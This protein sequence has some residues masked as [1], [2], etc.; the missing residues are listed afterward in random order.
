[1]RRLR[2]GLWA[3]LAACGEETAGAGP[4]IIAAVA[5]DAGS[6]DTASTP[7]PGVEQDV[8]AEEPDSAGTPDVTPVTPGGGFGEACESN[9]DCANGYCVEGAPGLFCTEVCLDECPEGFRCG[10]VPQSSGDTLFLCLPNFPELCRPCT[11]DVEC[12]SDGSSR[13]LEGDNARFCGGECVT[14]GCPQGFSCTDGQ[15]RPDSGACECTPKYIEEA[16][17]T[18]CTRSNEF[19]SCA[20]TRW[21]TAEGLSECEA[22]APTAESCNGVDDDCDGLTDEESQDLDADGLADCVD[23]DDDGD[24]VLD[25]LDNCPVVPNAPQGDLDADG[26]GDVCDDDDDGDGVNDDGDNCPVG[27]NAGQENLEGDLLGDVCDEDDDGDGVNDPQDNCPSTPNPNQADL[28]GDLSG[29]ACDTDADADGIPNTSDNC[30][31]AANPGQTDT[32]A[33][34]SGNTCDPDDDGDGVLD[35]LDNCP[36]VQNPDQLDLNLDGLGDA[37]ATDDDGDGVADPIDNCPKAPNPSQADQDGD[38]LG[39]PCDLDDDGDDVLD[40]GDNC[41][42]VFNP[43]QLDSDADGLGNTCDDDDD[44]DTWIDSKDNCPLVANPGQE[45]SDKNGVGDAC[46][47]DADGDGHPNTADNCPGTA[48]ADQLDTDGDATGDACDADDDADGVPDSGDNCRVVANLDQ[49]NLDGDAAGDACEAD[50]DGDAV[51]DLL[52]VCPV[53]FDPAQADLDSDGMGDPCDADDDGDGVD[54]TID[55]CPKLADPSQADFD[56]DAL[57]DACDLDDDGDFDPDASDCAPKNAAVSHSSLESC[58]AADDNCNGFVD[59][60]FLDTNGDGEADCVD[61]DDDGD[62]V[63]DPL[64]VCPLVADDQTNTDGDT[65]GDACD[66]DDDNDGALDAVDCAPKDP[67]VKK[68]APEVCNGIDDDCDIAIDEGFADTDQDG[69]ANCVDGDDDG[70]GDLDED[71]CEPLDSTVWSAAQ[72]TCN[73]KDDDCDGLL[74]E[75]C[76]LMEAGWPTFKHNSRRTSHS[77][78]TDVPATAKLRWKR[79]FGTPGFDNS[80]AIPESLASVYVAHGAVFHALD[81]ATGTTLWQTDLAGGVLG[82]GGPSIRRDGTVLVGG[83]PRLDA[84]TPEGGTLW[85]RG[86]GADLVNGTPMVDGTG[87]IFVVA[88]SK[89]RALDPAGNLLW[90]TEVGVI[91]G[92]MQQHAAL[93]QNGLVYVAGSAHTLTAVNPSTGTIAWAY[94]GGELDTDGSP[95]VGQD[96]RVYQ[97]FS[98]TVV[99]LTPSGGLN[100]SYKGGL[101]DIDSSVAIFN[102]GFECCNPVDLVLVSSNGNT[103]LAQ[104]SYGGAKLWQTLFAKDGSFNS[105]PAVDRDGDTLLGADDKTIRVL[106]RAGVVKW[107]FTADNTNIKGTAALAGGLA[108]IG[109]GGGVLYLFAP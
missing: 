36:L 31:A 60:G 102:T 15:C 46:A 97:S 73:A 11:Q 86:F 30:P 93:G 81:P 82:G 45:D 84:L 65:Q 19:G 25:T 38:G 44:D 35:E 17:T 67:A 41:K 107:S 53:I 68:G 63:P 78:A 40:A 21:C 47:L 94:V 29:D 64:D 22:P 6:G 39:D 9:D 85:S 23:G 56:G 62:L 77:W 106:T 50:D 33:D 1:M 96:G 42:G 13:C 58:N 32:D 88:G 74:D 26:V 59:E 105:A 91:P 104:L 57:G 48:N 8:S 90:S 7:G 54:D 20:G 87:R 28:D 24:G 5:V 100:W 52:D 55:L 80:P 103:G 72:E 3:V 18:V 108:A 10:A 16:A 43:S 66:A 95:A 79:T 34:G 83:G 75:V 98:D 76:G 99:S 12:S 89:L 71:D 69:D 101:G 4:D 27:A 2:V 109:D 61:E 70:D 49:S 37:C 92:S 14:S 51:P